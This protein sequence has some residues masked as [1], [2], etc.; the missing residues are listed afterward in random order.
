MTTLGKKLTVSPSSGK[1]KTMGTP[2][3]APARL[4][5]LATVPESYFEFAGIAAAAILY[6]GL[7]R[8]DVKQVA[9]RL[10]S[11]RIEYYDEHRHRAPVAYFLRPANMDYDSFLDAVQTMNDAGGVLLDEEGP[12]D[13]VLR[14]LEQAAVK[15]RA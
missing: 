6:T 9:A 5:K 1:F 13:V 12:A 11:A 10:K 15:S 3:V 14:E 2:R 7:K 4:V 8:Q